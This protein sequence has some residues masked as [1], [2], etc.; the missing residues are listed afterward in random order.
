LTILLDS[1]SLYTR[2]VRVKEEAKNRLKQIEYFKHKRKKA[3]RDRMFPLGAPWEG[4]WTRSRH[5]DLPEEP[6]TPPD[7]G[8][9]PTEEEEME[10]WMETITP[11]APPEAGE[12]AYHLVQVFPELSVEYSDPSGVILYVPGQDP[13][14]PEDITRYLNGKR[15]FPGVNPRFEPDT[16]GEGQLLYVEPNRPVKKPSV[17]TPSDRKHL[18]SRA[19]PGWTKGVAVYQARK[20]CPEHREVLDRTAR[21]VS[22]KMLGT[23]WPYLP[24]KVQRSLTAAYR[25][26]IEEEEEMEDYT[27]TIESVVNGGSV[28]LLLI[29]DEEGRLHHLPVGHH[30]YHDIREAEGN[31]IG[32]T[33]QVSGPEWQEFIEFL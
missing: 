33:I 15:R 29:R 21:E 13:S 31:I 26:A 8:P 4:T 10:E 16:S 14:L 23:C 3:M 20:L 11:G 24:V 5:R 17:L 7:P 6:L 1:A 30:Q 32:R 9:E 12:V 18:S 2:L 19:I 27:G 25:S 22:G 28:F